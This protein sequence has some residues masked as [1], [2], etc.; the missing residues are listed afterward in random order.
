MG[1]RPSHQ[2]LF[3]EIRIGATLSELGNSGQSGLGQF[4]PIRIRAIWGNG[5]QGNSGQLAFEG[6]IHLH[7]LRFGGIHLRYIYY[8]VLILI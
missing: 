1:T 2:I 5:N 8:L 3:W 4:R 6:G 7:L